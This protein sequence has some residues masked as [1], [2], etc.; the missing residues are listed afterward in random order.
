MLEVWQTDLRWRPIEV[1]CAVGGAVKMELQLLQTWAVRQHVAD[2]FI[3]ISE[4][5]LALRKKLSLQ[6]QTKEDL[7]NVVL[8]DDGEPMLPGSEDLPVVE[9]SAHPFSMAS[10]ADRTLDR[11]PSTSLSGQWHGL[12][13]A[14][15]DEWRRSSNN[16]APQW[17]I[18]EPSYDC[19]D[20]NLSATE[21]TGYIPPSPRSHVCMVGKPDSIPRD[22]SIDD[23]DNDDDTKK[24]CH[25]F[26]QYDPKAKPPHDDSRSPAQVR[27]SRR[28][29]EKMGL[30]PPPSLARA[31]RP[32]LLSA[33]AHFARA[34]PSGARRR[35]RGGTRGFRRTDSRAM[36]GRTFA[37]TSRWRAR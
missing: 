37:I 30:T 36:T 1:L 15:A 9:C 17:F 10:Y 18:D 11:V 3:P 20:T 16:F 27:R 26:T 7:N 32:S 23:D 24:V 33:A 21:A 13:Y 8:P 19:D 29:L 6:P 25:W 35:G 31:S 22:A 34:T 5:G 14:I 4:A 2:V 28:L 12:A